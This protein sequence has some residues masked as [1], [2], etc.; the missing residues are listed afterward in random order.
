MVHD[1]CLIET[2]PDATSALARVLFDRQADS[3]EVEPSLRETAWAE[4]G[5]RN[6]W[7]GEAFAVFDYLRDREP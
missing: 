2:G 4:P 6:F 5:V 1:L 3:H 7:E